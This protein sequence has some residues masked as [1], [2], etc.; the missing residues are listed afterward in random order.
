MPVAKTPRKK[1]LMNLSK[2]ET[3]EV[4]RLGE[5]G[6]LPLCKGTLISGGSRILLKGVPTPESATILQFVCRNLH[7]NERI[8]TPLDPPMLIILNF[9]AY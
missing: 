7:E 9:R 5:R 1:R 2:R 3:C 4:Q 8:W 6:R